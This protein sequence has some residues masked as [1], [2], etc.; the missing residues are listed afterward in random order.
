MKITIYSILFIALFV[1]LSEPTI[2]FKPF[3]IEFG[4]P[5]M[6]FAWF[7]LILAIILFQIQIDKIAYKRGVDDVIEAAKELKKEKG[8]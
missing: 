4:K 3:S 6:P 5:Y 2:S 7:F 1:W 8:L